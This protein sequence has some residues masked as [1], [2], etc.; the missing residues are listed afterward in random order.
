MKRSLRDLLNDSPFNQEPTGRVTVTVDLR[1][2][3]A[4]PGFFE[5]CKS[6][7]MSVEKVSPNK[8]VGS[9]DAGR[10]AGLRADAEV[11]EVEISRTLKPH[12][13]DG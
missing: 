9:I 13:A 3:K 11:R 5:R 6:L 4:S 7:G 10:L 2:A 12:S 8:I 1:D